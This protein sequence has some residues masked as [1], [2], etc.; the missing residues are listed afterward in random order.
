MESDLS[1]NSHIRCRTTP[2]LFVGWSYPL[3]PP[4][5]PLTGI[6]DKT[7]NERSYHE[8]RNRHK[9]PSTLQLDK[10]PMSFSSRSRVVGYA[11]WNA[12]LFP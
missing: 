1:H 8:I 4:G 3:I 12:K 7:S 10:T 6:V 2:I 9:T 5:Q 11:A